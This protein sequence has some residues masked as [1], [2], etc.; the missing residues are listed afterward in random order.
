VDFDEVF[1]PVVKMT[2]LRFLLDVVMLEDLK[3]LQLD[4]KTAFLHGDLDEEIYMEQPQGFASPSREHLVCRLRKS[5]YGLKQALRQWYK[6]LD[7]FVRSI[8]F[9]RSDEDHYFYG[10]DAPDGSPIFLILYVDD[11]LLFDRHI[12]ELAELRRQMLLKFAM[13]D[14]GPAHHIVGMKITGNRHSRQSYLSQSDSIRRI[15]ERFSV[16]SA[17]SV[18]TPFPANLRLSR[19]DCPTAGPEGDHMKSLLYAPAGSSLI[20]AMVTTRPDIAHAVGVVSRFMHNP[21]RPL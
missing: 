12:E 13:K 16:H 5:L 2:T 17:Q 21:D 8:G 15:L 10:K 14:L 9:V 1:L 7:D 18:M 19:K 4:V 6:K 20:Y 11:M 3:L